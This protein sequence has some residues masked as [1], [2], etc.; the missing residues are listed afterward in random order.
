[1]RLLLEGF[2]TY[3]TGGYTG[4]WNSMAGTIGA[5]GREGTNALSHTTSSFMQFSVSN[6]QTLIVGC[7]MK[8]S[9]TKSWDLI[10][11][12]DGGTIQIKI[13]TDGSNQV[14]VKRNTTT[15]LNTGFNLP[16]NEWFYLEFKA[17]ISNGS[18]TY[19]VRVNGNNIGSGSGVDTQA[20]GNAYTNLIQWSMFGIGSA[21]HWLD[22]IYIFDDSGSFCNDFVGD[23]HVEAHF[24]EAPGYI[25]QWAG[26]PVDGDANWEK[27]DE[28][29]HDDDTSFVATS[30]IGYMDSYEFSD[31]VT[32]SGSIYAVQVNSWARK[33]DVGSRT[34]NAITRPV[35]TTYSGTSPASLGNTYS[36]TVF[37]FE[38]NPETSGY[39]TVAEI[40]A[41]EFGV[42]ME[43]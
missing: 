26:F 19:E 25:T 32:L 42:K 39:W 1:M 27:V 9:T 4:K 11:F 10:Q 31:L 35:S 38:F 12:F 7:A 29:A 16:T 37:G 8:L 23:V 22:D 41:A 30:G 43:A 6:K 20:T 2:D 5:G 36:Y 3:E 34:L 18:G 14:I 13:V 17:K 21:T 33:D 15:L 28:V 40:N 24:P